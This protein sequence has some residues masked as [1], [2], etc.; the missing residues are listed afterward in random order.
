MTRAGN[1]R[2]AI[3]TTRRARG[4]VLG[5]TERLVKAGTV[6]TTPTPRLKRHRATTDRGHRRAELA[7]PAGGNDH[8]QTRGSAPSD[9]PGSA[10]HARRREDKGSLEVAIAFVRRAQ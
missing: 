9:P 5:A 4:T 8:V 6:A 1:Q 7:M 2:R 3:S 10:S